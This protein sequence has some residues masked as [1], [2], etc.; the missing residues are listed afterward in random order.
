MPDGVDAGLSAYELERLAN[1][2]RN[3]AHLESL[4][5]ESRAP[6]GVPAR[7]P[8]GGSSGKSRA[9]P[10]P[11]PPPAE[12][13]RRSTRQ[14]TVVAPY[15]D[16]TP[17]P[18]T[19]RMLPQ[20]GPYEGPDEPPDVEEDGEA[21]KDSSAPAAP[22]PSL[23]ERP[24]PEPDSARAIP[25]DVPALLAGHLGVQVA[26]APTKLSA[27]TA[28]TRGR[29]AKFSKYAG[30]LEWK[31]AIVLWVNIGGKDYKNVF[32]QLTPPKDG[33]AAGGAGDASDA[34]SSTAGGGSRGGLGMTWY[35]SERNHDATPIVQRLVS[36]GKKT[37]AAAADGSSSASSSSKAA[38]KEA[39]LLFCR[40]P[41]EPYVCCGRLS[42]VKHVA[43]RQPLKFVWKL[44][45]APALKGQPDFEALMV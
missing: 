31:N 19:R 9:R 2:R 16:D 43:G 38:V 39:V 28:M 37:A 14:R 8:A 10:L 3:A 44:E 4:G 12:G 30:A 15:T 21:D 13:V 20:R 35:A 27:V 1:M 11:P 45:D 29:R 5:L 17:L 26:G 6:G 36:I 34:G 40:L 18:E 7:R 23:D 25:L 24:P 32:F 42:Y 22:L 33:G 41:G